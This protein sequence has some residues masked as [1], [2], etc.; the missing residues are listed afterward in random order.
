MNIPLKKKEGNIDWNWINNQ[1]FENKLNFV[2][3]ISLPKP[4]TVKLDGKNGRGLILK[5]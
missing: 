4:L 5:P 1:K 3:H 2:K